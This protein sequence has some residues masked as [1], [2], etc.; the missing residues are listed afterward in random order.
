MD[1]LINTLTTYY[2]VTFTIIII[3][4]IMILAI[5]TALLPLFVWSIQKQ[6]TGATKELIKL[7]KLIERLNSQQLPKEGLTKISPKETRTE[8]MVKEIFIES[9]KEFT[10]KEKLPELEGKAFR[11]RKVF[12]K[13]D[14]ELPNQKNKAG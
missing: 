6:T 12:F 5:I 14:D 3:A 9:K 7:N 11:R 10:R 4:T 1:D 2:G 13:P 8:E